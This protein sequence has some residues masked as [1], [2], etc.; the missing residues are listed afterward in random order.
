MRSFKLR[1]AEGGGGRV[2]GEKL[3]SRY[4][5]ELIALSKGLIGDFTA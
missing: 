1:E 5:S 2:E 3:E 4:L